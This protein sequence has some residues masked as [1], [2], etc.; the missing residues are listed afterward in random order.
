V[1]ACIIPVGPEFR[2]PDGVPN[3]PPFIISAM[4]LNG[5]TST[6]NKFTITP[7]DI[8]GDA[9]LFVRWLRDYPPFTIGISAFDDEVVGPRLDGAPWRDPI[10]HTF[11]CLGVAAPSP[12]KIGVIVS[13]KPFLS[14]PLNPGRVEGGVYPARVSWLWEKDCSRP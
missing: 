9:P 13:D 1:S 14:D 2:D 12:H 11:E 7:S 5:G 3:S 10:T 8:N 4:P 6:D